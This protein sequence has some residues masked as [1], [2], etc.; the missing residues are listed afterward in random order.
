MSTIIT[1]NPYTFTVADNMNINAVFENAEYN[2]N[3]SMFPLH[4]SSSDVRTITKTKNGDGSITLEYSRS[5]SMPTNIPTY[6]AAW[7][8]ES[9]GTILSTSNPYTFTPTEDMNIVAIAGNK[10]A[11]SSTPTSSDHSAYV[12]RCKIYGSVSSW[13]GSNKLYFMDNTSQTIN[14]Y[15]SSTSGSYFSYTSGKYYYDIKGMQWSNGNTGTNYLTQINM[16]SI[17]GHNFNLRYTNGLLG[18][19][20]RQN[21]VNLNIFGP[22]FI[23]RDVNVSGLVYANKRA[24][25]YLWAKDFQTYMD[26]STLT[27]TK[28]VGSTT[29]GSYIDIYCRPDAVNYTLENLSTIF[30]TTQNTI[31]IYKT[32]QY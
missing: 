24:L 26:N 12:D 21:N 29:S 10:P 31:T 28:R 9:D 15:G 2:I 1:D 11:P 4:T 5:G 14:W 13:S 7:A 27:G 30:N 25:V 6:F 16:V 22:F 3:T 32:L 19:Y 17:I 18:G 20:V 8:N 23:F